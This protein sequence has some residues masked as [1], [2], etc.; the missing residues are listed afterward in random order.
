MFHFPYYLYCSNYKYRTLPSNSSI[1]II[2]V[3]H[4]YS[5]NKANEKISAVTFQERA[6]YVFSKRSHDLENKVDYNRYVVY[7]PPVALGAT[8]S[9]SVT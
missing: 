5:S 6:V 8:K 4:V 7:N 1:N 3:F 9:T 2:T